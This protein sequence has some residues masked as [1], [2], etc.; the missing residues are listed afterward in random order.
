[1]TTRSR[2]NP[3]KKD[4]RKQ[5]G[6]K[7]T[8]KKGNQ[9]SIV[10]VVLVLAGL[11]LAWFFGIP[12][13]ISF[14]ESGHRYLPIWLTCLG[15]MASLIAVCFLLE[16]HLWPEGP[17]RRR[18]RIIA[19]ITACLVLAGVSIWQLYK[20]GGTADKPPDEAMIDTPKNPQNDATPKPSPRI[21]PSPSPLTNISP[22]PSPTR[23][24]PHSATP[25]PS[26]PPESAVT[27]SKIWGFRVT[28]DTGIYL[29]FEVW[30]YYD[31]ALGSN[32]ENDHVQ[33]LAEPVRK[34][35]SVI[36]R[37]QGWGQDVAV[38]GH[39]VMAPMGIDLTG[40]LPNGPQTTTA[41]RVY[42]SHWTKGTFY[43]QTFPYRK[44]WK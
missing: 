5:P 26:P 44:V 3:P 31:G 25:S 22:A 12:S 34:D 11:A 7:G 24:P 41:I 27:E 21:E 2:N 32:L 40:M 1:M 23:I 10:D 42:F 19:G 33:I 9:N 30:Y 43:A 8:Q 4:A 15:I 17:A 20:L 38:I 14:Y 6:A 39:K 28:R 29:E 36:Q 37:S 16:R 35:G 18:L 13:L